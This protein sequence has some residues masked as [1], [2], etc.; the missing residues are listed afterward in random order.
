[1]RERSV[2]TPDETAST[3]K[4]ILF[5]KPFSGLEIIVFTCIVSPTT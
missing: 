1:L 3:V 5:D 2:T 4:I